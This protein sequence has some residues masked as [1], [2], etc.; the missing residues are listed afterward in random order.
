[1]AEL[2]RLF[3]PRLEL[4]AGTYELVRDQLED[5]GRWRAALDAEVPARWPPELTEDVWEYTRDWLLDPERVG[6]GMWYVVRVEP[7]PRTLVGTVGLKGL[8]GDDGT[9]EVGYSIVTGFRRFGYATEATGALISRAFAD[10]RVKRVIAHTY[11]DLAA[12][13]GVMTRLGFRA[14]GPGAEEGTVRY[15]LERAAGVS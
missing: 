7:G 6:W 10:P 1:M 15:V 2:L 8:P 4:I 9:V 14:D 13:I 11:P 12:S 5:P 3:T